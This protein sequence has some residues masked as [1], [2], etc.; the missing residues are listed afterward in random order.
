LGLR[1]I[2]ERVDWLPLY[3]EYL[4]LTS[5]PHGTRFWPPHSDHCGALACTGIAC[6]S[7]RPVVSASWVADT[8]FEAPIILLIWFAV[9]PAKNAVYN[10]IVWALSAHHHAASP[11]CE[12]SSS[13]A[14]RRRWVF[15]PYNFD[16]RLELGPRYLYLLPFC[17]AR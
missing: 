2:C 4:L 9:S 17:A 11:P 15:M 6:V 12:P 3:K 16:R 10:P 8:G 14:L 13:C 1:Y 7:V 5:C